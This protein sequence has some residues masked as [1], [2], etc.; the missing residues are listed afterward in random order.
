MIAV[1]FHTR[2]CQGVGVPVP[3]LTKEACNNLCDLHLM[4]FKKGSDDRRRRVEGARLLSG[5]FLC[6]L[7]LHRCRCSLPRKLTPRS[8]FL[9]KQLPSPLT[10]WS[11][12]CD[13]MLVQ[14]MYWLAIFSLYSNLL[15]LM[16]PKYILAQFH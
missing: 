3:S 16:G 10:W 14:A 7:D 8:R 2:K 4:P 6:L 15:A 12:V 13:G 9:Q 1:L 5:S 11:K